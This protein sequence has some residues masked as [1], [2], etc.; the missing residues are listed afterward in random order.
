MQRWQVQLPQQL[1]VPKQTL[2]QQRI[3]QA[4]LILW[5]VQLQ[6]QHRVHN[7]MQLLMHRLVVMPLQQP[8]PPERPVAMLSLLVHQLQPQR[9]MQRMRHLKRLVPIQQRITLMS[10][11]RM[12][13]LITQLLSRRLTKRKALQRST[14]L[15]VRLRQQITQHQAQPASLTQL[16]KLCHQLM[17]LPNQQ[18]VLL[19]MLRQMQQQP[20]AKLISKRK[21]Q[22]IKLVQQAH[23]PKRV[24]WLMHHWPHQLQVQHRLPLQMQ[25]HKLHLNC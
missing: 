25:H 10:V 24:I 3:Q 15:I 18:P 9:T 22:L 6:T 11:L 23:M 4:R 21:S 19:M 12:L 17:S 14:Q 5:Q 8:M 2:K 13:L 16:H 20:L 7:L 1:Q